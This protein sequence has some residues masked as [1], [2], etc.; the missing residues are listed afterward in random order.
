[1]VGVDSVKKEVKSL[2]SQ[3]KVDVARGYFDLDKGAKRPP[4]HMFFA[5]EPGTGKTTVARALGKAYSAMGA[6]GSGEFKQIH[7]TDPGEL[8]GEY[9]TDPPKMVKQAFD[10]AEKSGGV[11]FIDEAQNFDMNS[12]SK[13][14]LKAMVKQMTDRD[15]VVIFAGYEDMP[16]RLAKID[17]GIPSRVP[18]K[19]T[20]PKYTPEE[21]VEIGRRQLKQNGWRLAS[22][23]AE[24]TFRD[25]AGSV[26]GQGRGVTQL[27]NLAQE[28]ARARVGSSMGEYVTERKVSNITDDDLVSAAKKLGIVTEEVEA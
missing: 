11:L 6:L 7:E 5:G 27:V 17:S 23:K 28:S 2:L 16:A 1:M 10:A 4:L 18:K 25:F 19:M 21:K 15:V 24:K 3:V 9:V 26:Q 14:A 13:A 8:S 20:F 12:N 22:P